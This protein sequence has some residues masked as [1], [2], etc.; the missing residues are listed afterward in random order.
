MEYAP[1]FEGGEKGEVNP[2]FKFIKKVF[3]LIDIYKNGFLN[4]YGYFY[5]RTYIKYFIQTKKYQY[6]KMFARHY[7]N[8]LRKNEKQ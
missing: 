8:Y 7:I 4:F 3:R 5:F 1:I 6:N 2:P